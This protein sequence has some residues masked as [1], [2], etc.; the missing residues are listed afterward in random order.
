[1]CGTVNFP[2]RDACFGEGCHAVRTPRPHAGASHPPTATATA[3]ASNTAAEP[4][5]CQGEAAADAAGAATT[6]LADLSVLAA[7][8]RGGG[9]AGTG[10]GSAGP[11]LAL[12]HVAF[13][14]ENSTVVARVRADVAARLKADLAVVVQGLAKD[15]RFTSDRRG[16]LERAFA[17]QD[18][19]RKGVQ[20]VSDFG[21]EGALFGYA[22]R[23]FSARAAMTFQL[24]SCAAHGEALPQAVRGIVASANPTV[25]S[26]GGGPGNDLFGYL[27][28][29]RH[30][31]GVDA[32]LPA[33]GAPAAAA[34]NDGAA[35]QRAGSAALPPAGGTG[36]SGPGP[37]EAS[38][39]AEP[40][41]FVLDFASGW[42]PVVRRVGELCGERIQFLGCDL[43][44]PFD[45]GANESLRR[46][47]Q[48][49]G[50]GATA[51]GEDVGTRNAGDPTPARPA[52]PIVYLFCY[53][54]S[55]VM[56]PSGDPACLGVVDRL[57]E[58]ARRTPAGAVMVFREPNARAVSII[59]RHHPHWRQGRDYW[60]LPG[61]GLLVSA[62]GTACT[63]QQR[64]AEHRPGTGT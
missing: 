28:F 51:S 17:L 27:L 23:K 13:K 38:R 61:D 20:R 33:G 54:L 49:R 3:T 44:A 29:A 45:A 62:A 52:A 41:L 22:K 19:M 39:A 10:A 35:V 34:G 43:Q 21:H 15:P 30:G 56:G 50:G 58:A 47:A 55:E 5:S 11:L 18:K 26:V 59:V 31:R 6:A 32:T 7:A 40:R 9:A 48:G 4:S 8:T 16:N 25:V 64:G 36:G 42:G 63:V 60:H 24:L 37:A 12:P 2:H 57:W 14:D 1:M 46:L 53:V